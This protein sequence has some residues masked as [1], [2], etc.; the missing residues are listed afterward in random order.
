MCKNLLGNS[1]RSLFS[2]ANFFLFHSSF[3]AFDSLIF[4]KSTVILRSSL[5]GCN[6]AYVFVFYNWVAKKKKKDQQPSREGSKADCFQTGT[7]IFEY[8]AG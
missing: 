3:Y 2:E 7:R 8:R 1:L 6:T 5:L 4:T